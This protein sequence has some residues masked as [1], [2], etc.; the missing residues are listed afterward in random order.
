MARI[1]YHQLNTDHCEH[2]RI[3]KSSVSVYRTCSD[4]IL[5]DM[6]ILLSPT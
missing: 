5:R 2:T 3:D 4:Y 6:M 1:A